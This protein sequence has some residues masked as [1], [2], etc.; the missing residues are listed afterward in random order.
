MYNLWKEN[1]QNVGLTLQTEPHSPMAED[2]A[3]FALPI[4]CLGFI[5]EV[6]I[7][8]EAFKELNMISASCIIFFR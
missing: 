3:Q 2:Q 8:V 7:L 6:Q 1:L 4:G 5:I